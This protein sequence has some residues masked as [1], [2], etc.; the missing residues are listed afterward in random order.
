MLLCQPCKPYPGPQETLY[1][2]F[3]GWVIIK[4]AFTVKRIFL[5]KISGVP[6]HAKI[7]LITSAVI[8]QVKCSQQ[9]NRSSSSHQCYVTVVPCV[10]VHQCRSICHACYLV[11]I[12]PPGHHSSMLVCIL[13]Q[14]IVGLPEVI[15]DVTG[16]GW[17]RYRRV[18]RWHSGRCK[19]NHWYVHLQSIYSTVNIRPR[20]T[21]K[22]I[23]C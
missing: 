1:I 7:V 11:A 18:R 9:C 20:L 12:V 6:N 21:P 8:K 19:V 4:I 13:P 2:I 3:T 22:F 10:V 23:L 5:C 16:A 17:E 15:K 14:P